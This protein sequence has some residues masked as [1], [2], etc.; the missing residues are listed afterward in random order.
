MTAVAAGWQRPLR[1]GANGMIQ[2]ARQLVEA[3]FDP[4]TVVEAVTTGDMT[5]LVHTGAYSVQLQ[6]PTTE[7][8]P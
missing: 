2:A 6:A 7:G 4:A 1:T 3:G 5:K 8:A